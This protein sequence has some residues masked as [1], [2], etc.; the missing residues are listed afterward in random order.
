MLGPAGTGKTF[1]CLS[2]I[3]QILLA[4]PDGPPLILLAP[5]QATFQLE[6]QILADSR[7]QGYSRLQI[8][9][10]ERVAGAALAWA[11]QPEQRLLAEDARVMVLHALL[12][13]RRKD[14]K[15]FHA[16][17]GLPGFA[18]QLSLELRELQQRQLCPD[19]L[20]QLAARDD[21]SEPL[22]RKLHDLS[23][24]LADYLDWM[25]RRS[26]RDGESLLDLATAALK[27]L[28]PSKTL[29]SALWMDGFA[30]MTPPEMDLLAA[31][32]ARCK[33]A[34]LAFCLENPPAVPGSWLS[35]WTGLGETF[36]QCQARFSGLPG[37]RVTVD[38]LKRDPARD[39]FA[40]NP[41]LRHLEEKWTQ[42]ED[43][44]EQ[45]G[46][47]PSESLR[48]AECA[49]PAAEAVLAAR[50]ILRFTRAGGRFR[51]AAVLLRR[52]DG[53]HDHLRR[54]FT[55]YEIPFFLD[56]R[57]FVAQHPL[58]ELTRSV[59]RA[60]AFGWQHEDWFAALKTGL[61]APEQ[62]AIDRLEN[63]ALERGWKGEAWFAPLPPRGGKPDWAEGLRQKWIGPFADFWNFAA[64]R[65]F[66]FD[67]PQLAQAAR[68]LWQ[69]L[70][71]EKR[72][73]DWSLAEDPDRAIHATIWEQMNL[74]LDGLELA[75]AEEKMALRDWLPVLEAGLAGLSVGVIPP[76]LDQVLIG[77][78]D[79]SRN[80]ELK[81][82]LVL[83]ANE[84]VFPAPPP[85]GHLLGEADREELA[86]REV[87]LG[88]RRREFL[89]RERFLGYIACT[90]AR[91]RLVVTCSR[92]DN[93]GAALNP[94]PFFAHLRRLFSKLP[95][96]KFE[97]PDWRQAEHLSEL[98]GQLACPGGR[99]PG[100]NELLSRP[101]FASL[102]QQMESFAC[103]AEPDRLE[104]ELAARLHGSALRT[105][106]SRL[107]DFAACAFK[108]F[109]RS[110]LRAE[111]RKRF[112]LDSRERGSFQH[113]VL[114]RF[115]QNLQQDG[116]K[117]RDLTPKE[118]RLRVKESAAQIAPGFRGGLLDASAPASFAART[119][120]ESLQD[121]VAATVEWMAH[122][123][124]DPWAVELGFGV[125]NG[126]LPAWEMD[127][128]AGRRLIFR[129]II[130]RVDLFRAEGDDAALA[131]VIDYKSSAQELN[132]V[133]LAHGLQLQLL[134]YLGVLRHLRG[135]REVFGVDKL[136][137]AGVFY[138][139]LRGQAENGST[140]REVME[141]Q[142][143]LR[144]R[145]YQHL[146]RFDFQALPYLDNRNA[147]EGAQ[148]KFRLK[149]DGEPYA[150]N[151]DLMLPEAFAAMLDRLETELVRMG[152]EIFDGAIG[153]NPFQKGRE[154]ACDK[155]EYQGI[156]RFDPWR[157]SYRV[158]R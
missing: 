29:A 124:F 88:Q 125:E 127:L 120:A 106:V 64:A 91:Q 1:R 148:F 109:V 59:L 154:L 7:L 83:G 116:K 39:R 156:C 49:N 142:E 101:A 87:R 30:E 111:E 56:R 152:G 60:A 40:R 99:S 38:I 4:E 5:K 151:S 75:F 50:E 150:N 25:Q 12:A 94:S 104:P 92:Q 121:F 89:G 24:L 153:V 31:V 9:S 19:D 57:R 78:I 157:N 71:V 14:L 26:L 41:V 105:S 96:E 15:V 23:I 36:R 144:Q 122:Y 43:F 53:Y 77:A 76:A 82:A 58:V 102:R 11:G 68:Q 32:A 62:E 21:L 114:A 118:A 69:D 100:L 48:L 113:E 13:R 133:K 132:K 139:N 138:V 155:C 129:G 66:R 149:L 33:Q 117:W 42:P 6:R 16:S 110:G 136:A 145:R 74:W 22:R 65:N 34:T 123:R 147:S 46:A 52:M 55:R 35:I 27:Q 93:Q 63:E 67:G 130:D 44:P 18:R 70:G 8:L 28:D 126:R 95:M 10:F 20:R 158:L 17:A 90:R 143:A 61:V 86:A 112:E 98:A 54:V 51:E 45:T 73:Q 97:L 146:G 128:G 134:A 103:V 2:E 72:L 107:E 81:L 47:S 119:V 137:P 131:V 79:R 84:T 115:H 85:E 141:N 108:F 3:R 140:R 37:A 80:P 135:A